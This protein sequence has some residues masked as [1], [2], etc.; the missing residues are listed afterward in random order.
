MKS[1][2][3]AVNGQNSKRQKS[4]ISMEIKKDFVLKNA[5]NLV[6]HQIARY[7]QYYSDEK[8]RISRFEI[9]PRHIYNVVF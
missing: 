7:T 4:K 3:S 5:D 2:G 8:I 1:P 6:R 9:C